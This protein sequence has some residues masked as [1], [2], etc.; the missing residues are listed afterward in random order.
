MIGVILGYGELAL[1]KIGQD[2]GAHAYIEQIIKA[3]RR[4]T[5]I[6]RQLLAFAI[7]QTISPAFYPG[8]MCAWQ[9]AIRDA[10]WMP[11]S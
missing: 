5:T 9:S 6:I 8:N 3:A 1:A 2:H 7:K 11:K 4:S 10:A